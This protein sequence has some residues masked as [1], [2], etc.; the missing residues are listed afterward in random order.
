[1]TGIG[2]VPPG[3]DGEDPCSARVVSYTKP[4][5]KDADPCGLH[6]GFTGDEYCLL[7]PK[8]GEGV[9]VHFGPKN[10]TDMA[11]VSKYTIKPGEEFNNS[12]LAHVPLTEDK[13]YNHITVHMRP[14]S[15]H[16]ISQGVNSQPDEGFYPG[17]NCNESGGGFGFGGGQ[18]LI[19]DNPPHGMP[20]PEN[21]GMGS[22]IK[23]NSSAC[24]NLHAYNLT[25]KVNLREIWVNL[26]FIDKSQI[27]QP[28]SGIGMIGEL[29]INLAAGE[30]QTYTYSGKFTGDGRIIQ[31]FGHRHKW[32]PRFAAW[33]NDTLIYDSHSWQES[34]TYDYDSLT[35]NP[36]IDP[37]GMKDGAASGIVKFTSGD[38]LKFSCFVENESGHALRFLNELEGGEMC[39]MWGSTVGPGLGG[40]FQ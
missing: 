35:M 22:T 13:S 9:Q 23:G 20:A 24:I 4:C 30:K 5:T 18:N 15:H 26:Y 29:G 36:P 19:Y 38:T 31:L 40:A 1:M 32:T 3:T 33:L 37:A 21:V 12:V 39:N 11:D 28:T 17:T 2:A 8:A 16:W 27:T 34:V 6:S 14:G 10:Y 25:D 7:P